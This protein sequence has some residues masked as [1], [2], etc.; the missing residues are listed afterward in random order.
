M[1]KMIIAAIVVLVLFFLC[2][3]IIDGN[4][5]VVKRYKMITPKTKHSHKFVILADLH[6][7]E[8]GYQN[9]KLLEAIDKEKPT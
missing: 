7:K 6:G 5:F 9:E 2:V 1:L 4:R 3:M 8:Y